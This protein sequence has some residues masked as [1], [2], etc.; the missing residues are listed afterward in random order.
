SGL[1]YM[2]LAL[3]LAPCQ[4]GQVGEVVGVQVQ[5]HLVR[6]GAADARGH[7]AVRVRAVPGAVAVVAHVVVAEG[8]Q[9]PQVRVLVRYDRGLEVGGAA[10]AQ[11]HRGLEDD[12]AGGAEREAQ[13]VRP[14]RR[15]PVQVQVVHHDL[16][17]PRHQ[18]PV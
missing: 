6:V 12:D 7:Q 16:P 4:V 17:G 10:S 11:G 13:D 3:Q 9:A 1:S 5:A 8:A 14:V 2:N 15:G 18:G